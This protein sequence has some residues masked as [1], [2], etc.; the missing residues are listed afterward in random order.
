ML[1]GMLAGAGHHVNAF[2]FN[3][4]WLIVVLALGAGLAYYMIFKFAAGVAKTW[5]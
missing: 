3:L 2:P 1:F 5:P 4:L